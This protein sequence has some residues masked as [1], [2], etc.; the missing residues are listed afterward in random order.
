MIQSK[1]LLKEQWTLNKLF[2]TICFIIKYSSCCISQELKF[3]TPLPEVLK[4]ASGM[5]V[6][7]DSTIA[8]INDHGNPFVYF[9]DNSTYKIKR[10]VYLNNRIIDWEDLT[11]DHKHNLYIGDF[12]NNHNKRQD[13]KIYV[14]QTLDT[15]NIQTA[16]I[17]KFRLPDQD[18]FPPKRAKMEFDIES[19][20]Y[21]NDYLYLFS[22]SRGIPFQGLIKVYKIPAISGDYEAELIGSTFIGGSSMYENWI[23]S[24]DIS[25]NKLV[26]L[27]HGK[28]FIYLCFENDDFFKNDP[29]TIDLQHFSQKESICFD[30]SSSD[31]LISDERTNGLLGGNFY[32]ISIPQLEQE[33]P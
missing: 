16:K 14:L 31:I 18:Q 25:G 22:K 11:T 23:T 24:A 8:M 13:L 15:N 12:G 9:I 20:A 7:D 6:I 21:H 5:E 3:I 2:F 32:K 4:G 30:D 10:T 33:C 28:I 19:M 17:I 1:F 26:L 29:I 27:T